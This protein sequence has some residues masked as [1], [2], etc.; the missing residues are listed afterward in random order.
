MYS[1]EYQVVL[2]LNRFENKHSS[3]IKQVQEM[4][5][6]LP[7][8]KKVFT[9]DALHSLADF[10]LDGNHQDRSPRCQKPTV[11]QIIASEN[12]YLITVKKNQKKLYQALES[13]T[14]SEQPFSINI[15]QEKSHGRQIKRQV[16]VFKSIEPL[17]SNWCGI[18]SLIRVKRWGKRGDK[19]DHQVAYYISS[20]LEKAEV[21]ATRIR[22]HWQIE[23]QLHWV[24]D[25]IFQEDGSQIHHFQAR[26]NLSIL[27]TIAMNL[28]RLLGFVSITEGQRW[29]NNHWFKL[30][31]LLE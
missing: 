18:Q 26:T 23:N 29:L 9:L 4:I 2:G 21:F 1:Q 20:L 13:I 16:S 17:K 30:W 31:I 15:E 8:T 6:S 12:H 5:G 25:V 11:Q 24:K 10:L 14:D 19:D 22:G 28:F 27:Q 3:E 7:F